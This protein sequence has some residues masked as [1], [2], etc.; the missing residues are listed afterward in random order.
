CR[1][2][3]K[4]HNLL[5]CPNLILQHKNFD[6][7]FAPLQ[8]KLSAIKAKLDL[9]KEPRPDLLGK[10]TQLQRLQ[11]HYSIVW[12]CYPQLIVI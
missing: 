10:K 7:G 2:G 4:M 12:Q 6:A 1:R 11:V 9:E 3:I 8:K 5:M